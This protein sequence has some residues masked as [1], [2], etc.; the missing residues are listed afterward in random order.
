MQLKFELELGY[1][2]TVSEAGLPD[3]GFGLPRLADVV[4]ETKN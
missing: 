4:T 3:S 1:P 2:Y